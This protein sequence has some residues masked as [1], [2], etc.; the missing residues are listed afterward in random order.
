MLLKNFTKLKQPLVSII[1]PVKNEGKLLRNLLGSIQKLDYPQDRIEV[2]I[3]DGQSTDDTK[4]VALN[5]KAKVIDNPKQTVGPGRNAA[6]KIAQ[7]E[8][9]AFSDADCEVDKNWL[10]NSLKYF[11]DSKVAGVGGPNF[12]PPNDTDFAKAVGF[13]LS[14]PL[15]SAGSTH[16]L[17]LPYLKEVASLPGCNAIYRQEILDKV[18]PIDESLLTCD[19]TEMNLRIGDLG[20]KL[21][22]VPYVFVWHYQRPTPKRLWQKIY[23][24]AIGRLQLGKKRKDGVNFIHILTGLSLP[25]LAFLLLFSLFINPL[26]FLLFSVS[27]CLTLLFF[28]LLA[29]IKTKSFKIA[30]N[31]PLVS[32]IV[33]IAW[34]TGFLKELLFPLKNPSG[35]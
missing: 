31:L 6:F 18:M 25:I 28:F 19:D 16:G 29:L 27:F 1:V 4:Q 14:Q 3:A 32:L 22:S 30:L 26:P 12:T 35:Y 21:L 20:Y 7:G 8:L 2:I 13:F 34:S 23:R 33:V 9:I 5:Y 10:K 24:W 17:N 15:F 11:S